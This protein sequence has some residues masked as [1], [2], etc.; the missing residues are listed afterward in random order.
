MENCLN[1]ELIE[2][3]E[4]LLEGRIFTALQLSILKKRLKKEH[5]D[6]N[7]KTYYY[8]FIKPKIR[9]MMAFFNIS[10]ININGKEYI[11]KNR[12]EAAIRLIHGLEQKHKSKKIIISGSFLFN[13]NYE[14]IDVFIFSKY[15]K[16][17]YKK[18]KIHVSFLRESALDSLF[19]SSLCKISVS[20]FSYAPN[21]KFEIEL[22][23]ILQIYELLINSIIGNEDYEK[24]LRDLILQ[25]EYISKG[26]ILDPKQLYDNKGKF[27]HKNMNLLSSSFINSLVL[28]YAA[29]ILRNK[30]KT[31]VNS[32]RK[33]LIEY[34][35]AKNLPIY[36]DTYSKVIALAG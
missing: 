27:S 17:D 35:K 25:T 28:G 14:D 12:L 24:N 2:K 13:K 6:S 36:I 22:S 9:A 34:D 1:L 8:K 29:K 15:D 5:L 20:N 7:E 18:G 23:S 31:Q 10:E 21:N 26:V 19:F 30:L 11:Q 33:L 3:N 16:E 4:S 32:Y